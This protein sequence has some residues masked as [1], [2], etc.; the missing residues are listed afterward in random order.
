MTENKFI[1]FRNVACM[2]Y[3]LKDCW[4]ALV[5][6]NSCCNLNVASADGDVMFGKNETLLFF[7]ARFLCLL[8]V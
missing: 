6:K 3:N 5:A 8:N 4:A 7:I 2:P 1:F